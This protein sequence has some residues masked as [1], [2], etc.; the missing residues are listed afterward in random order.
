[1]FS[2]E[3]NEEELGLAW[4]TFRRRVGGRS[5]VVLVDV[6]TSCWWTFRRRVGGRSN[7]ELV[8]VQTLS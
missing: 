5:D 1:M 4:W 3:W 7:V 2:F 6:P 8:D